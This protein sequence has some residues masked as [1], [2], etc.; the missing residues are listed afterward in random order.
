MRLDATKNQVAACPRSCNASNPR[1]AGAH[2]IEPC[3]F[4]RLCRVATEIDT[5]C[6]PAA[7]LAW[8]R[9]FA[10]TGGNFSNKD[11]QKSVCV[12]VFVRRA[13]AHEEALMRERAI[14]ERALRAPPERAMRNGKV[15]RRSGA[16]RALGRLGDVRRSHGEIRIE[17]M[18][19]HGE[20]K[21]GER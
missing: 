3:A 7:E 16:P 14:L 18:C 20:R 8:P 12:C 11:T 9:V 2:P 13:C 6:R 19:S 4:F 1:G 5:L 10:T 15:W 17:R 21:G